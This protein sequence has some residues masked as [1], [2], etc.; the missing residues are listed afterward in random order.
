MK[1]ALTHFLCLILTTAFIACNTKADRGKIEIPPDHS[2][3]IENAYK[4]ASN[5]EQSIAN[6]IHDLNNGLKQLTPSTSYGVKVKLLD[7]KTYLHSKNKELDSAVFYCKKLEKLAVNTQDSALLGKA[8]FKLGNY[9]YKKTMFDSSYYYHNESKGIFLLRNDSLEVGRQYLN[10]AIILSDI[11]DYIGSD[12]LAIEGLKYLHNSA[13]ARTIASLENC[14]AISAR[15]RYDFEDALNRYDRAIKNTS[16]LKNKLVYINNKANVFLELENYPVAISLFDSILNNKEL[17]SMDKKFEAKVKGNLAF[18]KWLQTQELYHGN[19]IRSALSVKKNEKDLFGQISSYFQLSEFYKVND[20]NKSAFY[21]KK[22]YDIATQ[23]HSV[24]DR[25]V[26]LKKIMELNEEASDYTVYA[27]LFIKLT[28]SLKDVR[29]KASNKFAKIKYESAK[30]KTEIAL[31]KTASVKKQL[32][33]ERAER[34]RDFSII[35]IMALLSIGYISYKNIRIKHNKEKIAQIYQT[36]THISKKIH[37]EI[38]NDVYNTMTKLQGHGFRD[39]EVILDDLDSI[40]IRARE[41]S[42]EHGSIDI[43]DDFKNILHD[44]F[45]NFKSNNVR[46]ITRGINKIEWELQDPLKRTTIYRVLQELLVNS[47]KHS[48]ATMILVVFK[49]LKNKVGIE[50]ADNGIG[51]QVKKKSG[52]L[53]VENRIYSFNGSINFES[54]INQGFKAYIEV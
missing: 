43:E 12:A 17:V 40:Y 49:V 36:E 10:M 19:N 24:E 41:I 31:L 5:K 46:V 16:N 1:I 8:Y 18:A 30:R 20:K 27:K 4:S 45:L 34:F 25:L 39:N 37:D 22:M 2:I 35:L 33:I 9:F 6:R 14:L 3:G 15:K 29:Y 47:K 52:L 26:A 53:N 54:E 38:A 28:D 51:C 21:A 44:L 42:K 23:L 48:D 7:L 11:G 32:S 13:D 50:Y